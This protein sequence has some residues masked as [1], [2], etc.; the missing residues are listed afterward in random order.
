M[1]QRGAEAQRPEIAQAIADL[2]ENGAVGAQMTGS[3]SAVFGV[4]LRARDCRTA[5]GKLRERYRHCRMM[6][7]QDTGVVIKDIKE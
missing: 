4:F 6:S 1:L 2:L 5:C 3:G 7:T